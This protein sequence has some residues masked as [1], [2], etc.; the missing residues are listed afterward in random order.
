MAHLPIILAAVST[1][2]G[3]VGAIR[4]GKAAEKAANF[5]AAVAQ[6]NAQIARSQAKAEATQID[7]LNRLR[8]GSARAAIGASGIQMEGSVIEVLGDVVVQG[9][10]ERQDAIYRGELRAIGFQDTALLERFKGKEAARA[11][12]LRAATILLK[13]GSQVATQIGDISGGGETDSTKEG[14]QLVR[15]G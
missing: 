12:K 14:Q 3:A 4:Q 1:V 13:G 7:R 5:N 6:R 9:E 2:V 15:L 11:G 10:L 8:I